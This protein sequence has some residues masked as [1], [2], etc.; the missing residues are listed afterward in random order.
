[1]YIVKNKFNV[2]LSLRGEELREAYRQLGLHYAVDKQDDLTQQIVPDE[3]KLRNQLKKAV[4][5][6]W[7]GRFGLVDKIGLTDAE[8]KD[9]HRE[10]DAD[11]Y[12]GIFEAAKIGF[13]ELLPQKTTELIYDERIV[14]DLIQSSIAKNI[15]IF[16]EVKGVLI[17]DGGEV[18][19]VFT[20]HLQTDED[21]RANRPPASW[22][23]MKVAN[24]VHPEKKRELYYPKPEV[25]AVLQA[26]DNNSQQLTKSDRETAIA[27][28]KEQFGKPPFNGWSTEQIISKIN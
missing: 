13:H 27:K 17:W 12:Y 10:L 23:V 25:K 11:N 19:D 8:I 21:R 1:M 3:A 14:K 24:L 4:S 26:G 18:E 22:K 15:E 6:N 5:L 2:S 20:E 28:Y 7:G 9:I 16:D